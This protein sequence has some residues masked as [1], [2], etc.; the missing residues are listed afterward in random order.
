M[1]IVR[2][3]P[4]RVVGGH[5]GLSGVCRKDEQGMPRLGVMKFDSADVDDLLKKGTFGAVVLH[6][7][8][9]V[10]GFGV[11]WNER[12]LVDYSDV[13][14]VQYKGAGGVEGQALIQGAC[15]CLR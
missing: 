14:N 12:D 10:L 6:E 7:M 4:R 1:S 5:L 11:L 9:H 15:W 3:S 13:Y 2:Y 8:A